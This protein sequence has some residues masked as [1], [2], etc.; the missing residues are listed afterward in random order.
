MSKL[1]PFLFN[2][3][4]ASNSAP[5]MSSEEKKKKTKT[6]N[7][8]H[9]PKKQVNNA[10]RELITVSSLCL[11]SWWGKKNNKMKIP[12]YELV[13]VALWSKISLQKVKIL[14]QPVSFPVI[15]STSSSFLPLYSIT[16]PVNLH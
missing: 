11:F 8:K 5:L 6:P 12:F 2:K 1:P 15:N 14:P 4:A 16:Y 13:A 10:T 9:S 7:N 3:Q